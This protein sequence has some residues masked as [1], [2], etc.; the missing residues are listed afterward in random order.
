MDD[1]LTKPVR[2]E[3]LVA[4]LNRQLPGRAVSEITPGKSTPEEPPK[5]S[6][7]DLA[8]LRRVCRGDEDQVREMLGLFVS[9]TEGLLEELARALG[10]ERCHPGRPPGRT[11]SRAH[12]PIWAPPR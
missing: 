9:S 10:Q 12:P 6:G 1:Y 11:R 8:K 3:E 7:F 4:A 5:A 2:E